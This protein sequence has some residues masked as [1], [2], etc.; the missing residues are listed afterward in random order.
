MWG[1]LLSAIPE[2]W[3]L[4]D[5]QGGRPDLRSRF[6]KGAAPDTNPGATGGTA[7]HTHEAHTGV[8]NH[9][10]TVSVTDPGHTHNQTRLPTATG[11]VT[12][13]TVDTSMSGTPATS[14]VDTGSRTTGITASTANPGGGVSSIA[15][16]TVNHEPAYYA[17]AFIQKT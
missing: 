4:C 5:G 8:M 10:H 11:A 6:I 15:H 17:L 9:T 16:D 2:G 14:G 3:A 12:G 7:S 13:F 1:G